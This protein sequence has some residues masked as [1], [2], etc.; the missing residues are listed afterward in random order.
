MPTRKEYVEAL[1]REHAHVKTLKDPSR[2][3]DIESELARFGEKPPRVS[4]EKAAAPAGEPDD[5]ADSDAG[6]ESGDDA[7]SP[8]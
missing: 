8:E 7:Q 4:R 1:K 2:L 6:D 3:K 5:Q